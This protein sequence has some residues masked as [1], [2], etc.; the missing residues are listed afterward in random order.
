MHLF[1]RS[2]ILITP[3]TGSKK[4]RPQNLFWVYCRW[5]WLDINSEVLWSLW[6]W[7]RPQMSQNDKLK[8]KP[9]LKTYLN[10]RGKKRDAS[11]RWNIEK[12]GGKSGIKDVLRR[13]PNQNHQRSMICKGTPTN[14]GRSKQSS[15]Y[16][17]KL[18]VSRMWL[19]IVAQKLFRFELL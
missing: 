4:Q 3:S 2:M 7:I 11:K 6:C 8:W 18:N 1:L 16:S 10:L 19:P 14:C 15:K 17:F 9:L 5:Q 12:S 13:A